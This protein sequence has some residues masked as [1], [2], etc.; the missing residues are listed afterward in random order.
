MELLNYGLQYSIAKHVTSY[1]IS[2]IIETEKPIT[3]RQSYKTHT[4]S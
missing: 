2:L 4:A 3:P 1:T